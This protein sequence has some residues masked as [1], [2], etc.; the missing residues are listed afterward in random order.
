MLN[1]I[2]QYK[3][4]Q[5]E[6]VAALFLFGLGEEWLNLIYLNGV[7]NNILILSSPLPF[8]Q[9]GKSSKLLWVLAVQN[10]AL[11]LG[12]WRS[13]ASRL[14]LYVYTASAKGAAQ[15]GSEKHQLVPNPCYYS[16]LFFFF[17]FLGGGGGGKGWG[18][19]D[20]SFQHTSILWCNYILST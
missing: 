11:N 6:Y 20:S 16:F 14:H 9:M 10:C 18:I 7:T 12:T 17:F 4:I 3:L 15:K 5:L 2:R 1:E 19:E 8:Y 13:N